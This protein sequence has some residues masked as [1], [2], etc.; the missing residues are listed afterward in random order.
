M[1]DSVAHD[2]EF[3]FNSKFNVKSL[4]DFQDKSKHKRTSVCIFAYIIFY[5]FKNVY[6]IKDCLQSNCLVTEI[7]DTEKTRYNCISTLFNSS[8]QQL[9][10]HF[11]HTYSQTKHLSQKI[12]KL[13]KEN[14]NT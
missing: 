14:Y 4:E 12:P 2:Q 11:P 7:R 9:L 3:R 1:Q 13:G 5:I 10:F 8:I 6:N